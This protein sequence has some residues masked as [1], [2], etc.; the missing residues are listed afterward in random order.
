MR[1]EE[2]DQHKS[3]EP[4]QGQA[5][6]GGGQC[7]RY[8]CVYISRPEWSRKSVLAEFVGHAGDYSDGQGNAGRSNAGLSTLPLA[9]LSQSMSNIFPFAIIIRSCRYTVCRLSRRRY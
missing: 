5:N 3:E 1:C 8:I 6:I 2:T 4:R 9:V 7:L